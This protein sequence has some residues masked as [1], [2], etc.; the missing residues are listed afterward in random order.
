MSGYAR[1]LA[2]M[3][4]LVQWELDEAA[5]HVGAGRYDQHQRQALAT[6]LESLSAALRGYPVIVPGEIHGNGH[7]PTVW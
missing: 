2:T 3:L 4:R 7:E 5:H 1:Q 6:V